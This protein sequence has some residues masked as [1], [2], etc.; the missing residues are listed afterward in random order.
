[1]SMFILIICMYVMPFLGL[2][3]CIN[4][5]SIIKKVKN[6]EAYGLNSF[7]MTVSFIF[8]VWSIGFAS[9]IG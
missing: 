4:L 8:I 6:E 1:M 3:F 7:L 2:I 9:L 5:L